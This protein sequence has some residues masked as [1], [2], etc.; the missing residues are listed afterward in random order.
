MNDIDMNNL[1]GF[2]RA[3]A[4]GRGI[5]SYDLDDIVQDCVCRALEK[6]IT[7]EYKLRG[8]ILIK[9]L[10]F[11]SLK[12]RRYKSKAVKPIINH[13][14]IDRI[15]V[16]DANLER[17]DVKDEIDVMLHKV[18]SLPHHLRETMQMTLNG[19]D[20]HQIAEIRG[21]KASTVAVDRCRAVYALR[22]M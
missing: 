2:T 14:A 18:A 17:I 7:D 9:V 21:I 4:Y 11:K 13:A 16:I 20:R 12:A 19:M 8:F 10:K 1:Y 5:R 22:D 15:C 3:I 6:G